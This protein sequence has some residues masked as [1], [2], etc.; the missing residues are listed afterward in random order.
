ML[1]SQIFVSIFIGIA[2]RVEVCA[3]KVRLSYGVGI[4]AVEIIGTRKITLDVRCRN[5]PSFYCNRRLNASK[6]GSQGSGAF[7]FD[8]D[9]S[10]GIHVDHIGRIALPCEQ[11]VIGFLLPPVHDYVGCQGKVVAAGR[12]VG[13]TGII[14]AIDLK[15]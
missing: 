2:Q 5:V 13:L 11:P 6:G 12:L 9:P 7:L 3:G 4:A 8:V 1:R 14:F 10:G 15:L